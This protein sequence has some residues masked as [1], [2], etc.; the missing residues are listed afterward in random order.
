MTYFV[1]EDPTIMLSTADNK[2]ESRA[3]PNTF[4]LR[5]HW[6]LDTEKIHK[7]PTNFSRSNISKQTETRQFPE[8]MEFQIF[9]V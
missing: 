7:T 9:L 8:N 1:I 2:N 4:I 3:S 6:L 5:R